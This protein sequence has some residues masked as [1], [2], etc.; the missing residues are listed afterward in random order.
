MPTQMTDDQLREQQRQNE[1]EAFLRH[2]RALRD[3]YTRLQN[4][5]ASGRL[6]SDPMW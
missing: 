3:A 5:D 2:E 1:L 4:P 6:R